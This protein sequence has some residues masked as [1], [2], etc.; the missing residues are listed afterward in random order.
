MIDEPARCLP[1]GNNFYAS[2]SGISRVTIK[3]A[4]IKNG[5]NWSKAG[6]TDYE[7]TNEWSE[8]I[9]QGEE[10]SPLLSGTVIYNAIN[11]NA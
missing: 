4:F 2:F 3:E 6:W 11:K 9:L 8:L 10:H 5:W 1:E 7:L